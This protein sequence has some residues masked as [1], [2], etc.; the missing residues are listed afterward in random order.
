MFN[1]MGFQSKLFMSLG[2]FLLVIFLISG[3]AFY[4]YTVSIVE[5]N[6]INT[7]QQV[8][9]KVQEQIDAMLYDMDRIAKSINS[10][11]YLME[12]LKSIPKEGEDNYFDRNPQENN[13]VRSAILAFTSLEPLRGR[14]SIITTNHDYTDVNN[15]LDNQN[16]NK[17]YIRSIERVDTIM[18]SDLY[19]EFIPPHED[20][21]SSNRDM[22]IS[23]VRPL[24]DNYNVYGV[25]EVNRHIEELDK[26]TSF[27]DSEEGFYTVI[28]DENNNLVYSNRDTYPWQ[29]EHLEIAGRKSSYGL[30]ED[31]DYIATYSKMDEVDWTVILYQNKKEALA[32]LSNLRMIILVTYSLVFITMLVGLYRY[33]ISITKPIRAL[34]HNLEA[35]DIDNFEL[36][37]TGTHNEIHLLSSAFTNLVDE[38]K[39]SSDK[40]IA[41]NQRE[42]QAYMLALQ[43]Q[44]NPHFLYNTLA[45]IGVHGQTLG[46]LTVTEMCI[47]LANMLRYTVEAKNISTVKSEVA[48]AKNYLEL[49]SKRYEENFNYEIDISSDIDNVMLPKLTIQPLVENCFSHGFD[50]VE[51]PWHIKLHGYIDG[52]YDVIKIS[53]NGRGISDMVIDTIMNA[54]E[55]AKAFEPT[56]MNDI[57]SKIGIGVVNTF[58]RLFILFD[59]KMSCQ[60][61]NDHG[62]VITIKILR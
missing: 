16:V 15:K 61:A 47:D 13:D 2:F 48:Q 23:V 29:D 32:P 46:N 37:L 36:E 3:S 31:N 49:M 22:V 34:R 56:A 10:S 26:V 50:D 11:G 28:L 40:V 19:K 24:R 51:P 33:S 5:D 7:Q 60:I 8:A 38:I 6:T 59:G 35:V 18:Q 52:A 21:W 12:I 25:V 58:T 55:E 62:T 41:A 17:A 30:L 57:N 9:I 14:I 44:L 43:A 39:A 27:N 53:D 20:I 1:N 4:L 54:F 42:S 45:V